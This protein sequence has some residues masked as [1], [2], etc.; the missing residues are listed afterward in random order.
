M[1]PEILLPKKGTI[2]VGRISH[3]E[4]ARRTKIKS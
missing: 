3:T 2:I 1:P 4:G